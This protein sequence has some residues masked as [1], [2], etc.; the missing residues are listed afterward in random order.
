MDEAWRE[1]WQEMEAMERRKG[2]FEAATTDVE[3]TLQQIRGIQAISI[4]SVD[5]ARNQEYVSFRQDIWVPLS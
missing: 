1:S 3:G 4:D 2:L 5:W